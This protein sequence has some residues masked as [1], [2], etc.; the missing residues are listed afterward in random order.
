MVLILCWYVNKLSDSHK[1][2]S[3]ALKE[4]INKLEVAITA[5]ITKLGE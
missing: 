4:S 2:E 3:T 1:E 5:L